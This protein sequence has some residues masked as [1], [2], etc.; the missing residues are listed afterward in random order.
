[1]LTVK[2]L[3]TGQ[4]LGKATTAATNNKVTGLIPNT[5]YVLSVEAFTNDDVLTGYSDVTFTTSKI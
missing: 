3:T 1:V 5:S 4:E 2:L